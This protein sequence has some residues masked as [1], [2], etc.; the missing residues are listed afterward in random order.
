MAT[1]RDLTQDH[2]DGH[3][4]PTTKQQCEEGGVM[5]A[6]DVE[7]IAMLVQFVHLACRWIGSCRADVHEVVVKHKGGYK[8]GQADC[9]NENHSPC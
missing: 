2:C 8:S 1:F 6:C 3:Q 4:P 9:A 5:T 7:E